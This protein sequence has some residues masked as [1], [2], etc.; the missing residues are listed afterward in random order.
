[1]NEDIK[2]MKPMTLEEKKA[3]EDELF[4][5]TGEL[6]DLAHLR[7]IRA[8]YTGAPIPYEGDVEL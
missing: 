1:M 6:R 5:P 2:E 4:G 8:A 7:G 3:L